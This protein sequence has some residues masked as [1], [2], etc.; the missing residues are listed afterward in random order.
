MAISK[1]IEEVPQ[2]IN[3][4]EVDQICSKTNMASSSSVSTFLHI[5]RHSIIIKGNISSVDS[6]EE[7]PGS[8]P[9]AYP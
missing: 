9:D 8:N 2:K 1:R 3:T 4:A 7:I 6:H 5:V